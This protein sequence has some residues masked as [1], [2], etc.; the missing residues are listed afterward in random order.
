MCAAGWSK[1]SDGRVRRVSQD[2]PFAVRALD[3][4]SDLDRGGDCRQSHVFLLHVPRQVVKT[5]KPP[6]KLR[7]PSEFLVLGHCGRAT[8]QGVPHK[9]QCETDNKTFDCHT[10]IF[11]SYTLPPTNMME[12]D[13]APVSKGTWISRGHA[14]HFRFRE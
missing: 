10:R 14:I 5:G 6:L 7:A 12:V 13:N 2:D 4:A 1:I 3:C 9:S 8:A 11:L